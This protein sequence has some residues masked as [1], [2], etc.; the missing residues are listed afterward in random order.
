LRSCYS[1]RWRLYSDS[2]ATT[3]GRFYFVP[4]GTPHYPGRHNLGSRNWTTAE[5]IPWPKLGEWE[6]AQSWSNGLPP[7]P[8]PLPVLVGNKNCIE[9]GEKAPSTSLSPLPAGICDSLPPECY[10]AS[11]LARSLIDIG[12]CSAQVSFAE[13]LDALYFDPAYA[14]GLLQKFLGPGFTYLA[15]PN[16]GN[17]PPG[18]IIAVGPVVVVCLA[19]TEN[20]W[21]LGLQVL[22]AGLGPINVGAFSTPAVWFAAA[23]QVESL[24]LDA[25]YI[26]QG[27]FYFVGH[28]FGGA[29]CEVLA[30]RMRGNRPDVLVNMLTFG[31]PIAGDSRLA[32][33]LASCRQRNFCIPTDPVPGMP[34]RGTNL[35]SLLSILVGGL[36]SQWFNLV[37]PGNRVLLLD[38]G[39]QKETDDEFLEFFTQEEL[40]NLIAAA[41]SVP[42]AAAHAMSNY[43]LRVKLSCM[44]K[45]TGIGVV[46]SLVITLKG[47]VLNCPHG[48]VSGDLSMTIYYDGGTDFFYGTTDISAPLFAEGFMRRIVTDPAVPTVLPW[49]SGG[50]LFIFTGVYPGP[51]V[52][53]QFDLTVLP[54]GITGVNPWTFPPA[55]TEGF[56]LPPLPT[57]VIVYKIFTYNT[58]TVEPG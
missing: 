29:V 25:G 48:P 20:Y 57:D 43:L 54:F 30:G 1:S 49:S 18:S 56:S 33:L 38:D 8:L 53:L 42:F 12:R 15:T 6:G 26:N 45:G 2:D 44:S 32:A 37:P 41:S 36:F 39:T 55:T 19:G 11:S 9:F 21:Q 22:Y 52:V 5:R 28:S 34:P 23:L 27:E 51:Y 40:A 24:I 13:V 58:L 17:L 31:A 7:R 3:P 47:F 4:K 14:L 46:T 35:L 16:S 50:T 10:G